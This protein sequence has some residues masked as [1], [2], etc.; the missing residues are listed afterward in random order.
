L[1]LDLTISADLG[2]ATDARPMLE[3]GSAR[4]APGLR[5]TAAVGKIPARSDLT[6]RRPARFAGA[7][8]RRL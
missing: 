7:L 4:R 1:L 2:F 5:S 3:E 6:R 8:R